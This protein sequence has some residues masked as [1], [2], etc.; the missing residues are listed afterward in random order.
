VPHFV[1]IYG[2]LI[3]GN[4]TSSATCTGTGMQFYYWDFHLIS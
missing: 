2:A 3:T 1:T 4:G